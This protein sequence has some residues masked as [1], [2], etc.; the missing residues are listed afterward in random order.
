MTSKDCLIHNGASG[1]GIQSLGHNFAD[2][3]PKQYYNK[4]TH[5]NGATRKTHYEF[6]R[7]AVKLPMLDWAVFH[8]MRGLLLR[9]AR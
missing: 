4:L 6:E 7:A 2:V 9:T 3:V 5:A 1:F 8:G